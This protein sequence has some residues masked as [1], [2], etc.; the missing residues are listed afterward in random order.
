[1]YPGTSTP[2]TRAAK[3]AATRY[4]IRRRPSDGR[5]INSAQ[6]NEN[7]MGVLDTKSLSGETPHA[8]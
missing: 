1:M 6:G 2:S 8:G 4:R 5:A 7:S 3:A